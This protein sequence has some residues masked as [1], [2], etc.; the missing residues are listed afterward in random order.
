MC[1]RIAIPH[2]LKFAVMSSTR[3]QLERFRTIAK[4]IVDEHCAEVYTTTSVPPEESSNST[5][6]Y[7]SHL[8]VLGKELDEQANQFLG[9]YKSVSEGL[10][11]E[12]WNV[13]RNYVENFVRR[14]QPGLY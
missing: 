13:C 8:D 10:R 2:L 1:H 6:T 9:S 7:Y 4:R 12:I 5:E 11:S 14:N 3:N